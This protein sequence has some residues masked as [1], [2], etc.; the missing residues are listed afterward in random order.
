M[1][2]LN[3]TGTP[4]LQVFLNIDHLAS[5]TVINGTTHVFEAG[6]ITGDSPWKVKETPEKVRRLFL[7][8][9]AA[10]EQAKGGQE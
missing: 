4:P 8:A 2:E 6:D 7:E 9:R 3:T 1:I 10:R 5:I